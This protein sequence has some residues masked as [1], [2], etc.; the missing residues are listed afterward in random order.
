MYP[1]HDLV[2][3]SVP[4]FVRSVSIVWCPYCQAWRTIAYAHWNTGIEA[5]PPVYTQ[6]QDHG[7]FDT[8]DD[9]FAGVREWLETTRTLPAAP[10]I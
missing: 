1:N 6:M 8:L 7:P 3:G 10:G 5:T 4:V 2:H 9:V